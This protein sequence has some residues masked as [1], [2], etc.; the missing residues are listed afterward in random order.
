M[1]PLV[2]VMIN[3]DSPGRYIDLSGISGL[4]AN[5]NMFLPRVNML[6]FDKCFSTPQDL[7]QKIQTGI[8]RTLTAVLGKKSYLLFGNS[9]L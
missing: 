1:Y 8:F 6:E 9:Q 5:K 4:R 3:H 2:G 7:S